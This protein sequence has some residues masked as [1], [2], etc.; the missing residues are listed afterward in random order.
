MAESRGRASTLDKSG[1]R[2]VSEPPNEAAP[3]REY[4]QMHDAVTTSHMSVDPSTLINDRQTRNFVDEAEFASNALYHTDLEIHD[5]KEETPY[6][7]HSRGSSSSSDEGTDNTFARFVHAIVRLRK[8]VYIL[9]LF[10]SALFLIYQIHYAPRRLEDYAIGQNIANKATDGFTKHKEISFPLVTLLQDLDPKFIPLGGKH[11]NGAR[12][13]IIGDVHGMKKELL[14]LL[15]KVG[16][17]QA[18][19]HLILTGDM[20]SKGP[21]SPGVVDLMMKVGASSV[22]GNHEDKVLLAHQ[23]MMKGAD[24]Y[25]APAWLSLKPSEE[26]EDDERYTTIPYAGESAES[27]RYKLKVLAKQFTAEQ[28]SWLEQ[29][30]AILRVGDIEGIGELLV[31]HAGI[32]P[33]VKLEHQDPW[34]VMNMRSIDLHHWIPNDGRDGPNWSRVSNLVTE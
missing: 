3:Y 13:I 20:V 7:R 14:K 10:L 29:C 28:L 21:D 18:N 30:P 12:L 27:D 33:G 9:L 8:L 26:E 4:S 1:R 31:V 22:R 11:S 2:I 17:D 15:D 34:D 23:N 16:F 24:V 6:A 32:L 19:D 25:R 5:S